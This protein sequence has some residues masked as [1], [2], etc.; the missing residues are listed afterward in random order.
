M[1]KKKKSHQNLQCGQQLAP[2]AADPSPL[3][4]VDDILT[5]RKERVNR[6]VQRLVECASGGN[7]ASLMSEDQLIQLQRNVIEKLLE[8]L[9]VDRF[10]Q[11]LI[12][13][14]PRTLQVEVLQRLVFARQ[15]LILVVKTGF[16]KSLIFHA[17]T[18]LTGKV[19]II[20]VLL[21][22]LA[23]Q[24]YEDF[25]EIPGATPI[26]VSKESRS[27]H[28]DIFAHICKGDSKGQF[29]HLI[30][31][32]E[33]LVSPDFRGLL[34]NQEFRERIGSLVIDE[35]H[36]VLMW[37]AFRSEYAQIHSVRPL[38][39]PAAVL[40][41]CTATL[42]PALERQIVQDTRFRRTKV[43]TPATGL[44]RGSIDRPEIKLVI[45][46]MLKKAP[47]LNILK[48]LDLP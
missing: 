38:L 26:V 48:I 11:A 13:P 43:W 31:G 29:T 20:I 40:F 2:P 34:R 16:G 33:Q 39:P 45:S 19:S 47:M 46:Q 41:A 32:P 35:A 15:D 7:G 3:P 1:A 27:Q 10:P 23:D 17:W 5:C 14:K 4:S 30:M 22:R 24:T 9:L 18:I 12:R 42:N 6:V 21:L 8:R 37:S 44:I 28:D 36:C 25:C